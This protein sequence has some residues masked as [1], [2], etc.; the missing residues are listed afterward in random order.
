[1]GIGK[2]KI[3]PL[4]IKQ[5][6]NFPYD[7]EIEKMFFDQSKNYIDVTIS[8]H[9]FPELTKEGKIKECQLIIHTK[10]L[11]YEVKEIK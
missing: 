8:G 10:E 11:I 2:V 9:D 1:M 5:A 6:L 3:S 7:W 4:I